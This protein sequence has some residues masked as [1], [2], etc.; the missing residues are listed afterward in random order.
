MS[1]SAASNSS[2]ASASSNTRLKPDSNNVGWD[3]AIEVQPGN[4]KLVKCK[5]CAKEMSGGIH[6]IKEHIAHISGNVSK[7]PKSTKEDQ[8]KC[9][10]ELMASKNK[11]LDKRKHENEI[12]S[13]VQINIIDEENVEGELGSRKNPHFLGPID[14]FAS[15]I[16]PNSSMG[17]GKRMRQSN[18]NDSLFKERTYDVHHILAR[19]VYESGIPFNAIDNDS[20]KRFCEAVGQF[21]PGYQPPSQYLLREPLLKEEVER[22]KLSLKKQ[23]EEWKVNG[24]SIMT[25][26]WSDRKR[27]SVMNLCVNCKEGT[28]FVLLG[29]TRSRHIQ[30]SIFLIMLTNL[31]MKLAHNMLFKW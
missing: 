30:E 11:K 13:E 10:K 3:Y 5:L 7:C 6:R 23:E 28:T 20:F 29:K 25:D 19:W 1:L 18:L 14:R 12:R 16:N 21:G 31:L 26:A 8:E 17:E 27:R 9:L 15:K 22:T 4:T 24:C 2:M